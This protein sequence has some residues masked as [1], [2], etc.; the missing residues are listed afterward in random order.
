MLNCIAR[1]SMGKTEKQPSVFVVYPAALLDG[2]EVVKEH[3]DKPVSFDTRE[4]ATAYARTQAMKDGGAVIKLEDWYGNTESVWEAQ[5]QT[6][7][8]LALT[9][10]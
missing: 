2:W 10:A 5:P 7:R 6:G 9:T 3:D 1:K 4:E 8:Q